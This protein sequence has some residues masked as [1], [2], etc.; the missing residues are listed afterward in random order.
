MCIS[1]LF[2]FNVFGDLVKLK[3]YQME[4]GDERMARNASAMHRVVMQHHRK[5]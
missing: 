4:Q 1:N 2:F 5:F 3:L